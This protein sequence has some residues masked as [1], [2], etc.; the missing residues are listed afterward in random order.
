MPRSHTRERFP[1]TK[2]SLSRA[3]RIGMH[4]EMLVSLVTTVLCFTFIIKLMV[5]HHG[6]LIPVPMLS[7]FF[8]MLVVLV[9][10]K[11]I[12]KALEA[13]GESKR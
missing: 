7:I 5:T 11:A 12:C 8:V 3:R 9:R 2:P 13:R 1:V 10:I 4:I 6:R